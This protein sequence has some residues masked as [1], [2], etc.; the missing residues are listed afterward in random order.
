MDFFGDQEE[1]DNQNPS[2][3]HHLITENNMQPVPTIDNN[4]EVKYDPNPNDTK[5][6]KK[7]GGRLRPSA[8]D[9]RKV[10]DAAKLNKLSL[11]DFKCLETTYLR[12][13]LKIT[14]SFHKETLEKVMFKISFNDNISFED[15]CYM[16]F[17]INDLPKSKHHFTQMR[18]YQEIQMSSGR[19]NRWVL[20][21]EAGVC[22]MR[23]ALTYREREKSP[24]TLQNIIYIAYNLLKAL[25]ILHQNMIFHSD[26][27]PENIF[28]LKSEDN[29]WT[30]K[31]G[32]FGTSIICTEAVIKLEDV[33]GHTPGYSHPDVFDYFEQTIKKKE[34]VNFLEADL[35]SM[36][37]TLKDLIKNT[38]LTECKEFEEIIENMTSLDESLK[39]MQKLY[40]QHAKK[41]D[42]SLVEKMSRANLLKNYR[43]LLHFENDIENLFETRSLFDA[44]EYCR[45]LEY[46][47]LL[48]DFESLRLWKE[49]T[50]R[51]FVELY[52]RIFQN[53]EERGKQVLGINLDILEASFCDEEAYIIGKTNPKEIEKLFKRKEELLKKICE[54]SE[55]IFGKESL[56]SSFT[57]MNLCSFY[58]DMQKHYQLDAVQ[59]NCFNGLIQFEIAD[60]GP[61]RAKRLNILD[62]CRRFFEFEMTEPWVVEFAVKLYQEDP[63]LENWIEAPPLDDYFKLQDC[64]ADKKI[65]KTPE[66]MREFLK[67][68]FDGNMLFATIV[69]FQ[70]SNNYIP[71]PWFYMNPSVHGE[72]KI[73]QLKKV[74]NQ[75]YEEGIIDETTPK[76]LFDYLE[77]KSDKMS[78]ME[79]IYLADFYYFRLIAGV[80]N[81]DFAIALYEKAIKSMMPKLNY[82]S[83]FV[84][85]SLCVLGR[86]YSAGEE[87]ENPAK[88]QKYFK[89]AEKFILFTKKGLK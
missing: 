83:F 23:D 80:N 87:I 9:K 69:M 25:E 76:A 2:R 32:D 3:F 42:E 85:N 22:S 41:P 65:L 53:D 63:N 79:S 71:F 49:S 58:H 30:Y 31:I 11:C 19:T 68:L 46:F 56:A 61:Y 7:V 84:Y 75:Y 59:N 18:S 43:S 40:E 36:S 51:L 77:K 35:F 21:M 37:K 45:I 72:Y 34:T 64:F 12:S 10:L 70:K 6:P 52:Q 54:K 1:V 15:E 17:K 89:E 86:A 78:D 24:Y 29:E 39:R 73:K 57:K 33:K 8:I 55:S 20:S 16:M 14:N 67:F 74:A 60:S 62:V 82:K 50:I 66:E 5:V 28:L 38:S 26:I 88:S 44:M 47:L 48:R 13:Q 27:K 81:K 4:E